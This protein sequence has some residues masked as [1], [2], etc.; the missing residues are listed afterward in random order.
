MTKTRESDKKTLAS[1]AHL[2]F[3]GRT[4]QSLAPRSAR[5]VVRLLASLTPRSPVAPRVIPNEV[6]GAVG[7]INSQYVSYSSDDVIISVNVTRVSDYETLC[8]IKHFQLV[9]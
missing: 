3:P 8:S 2:C 7:I 9:S 6:R 4:I 1:S 5:A